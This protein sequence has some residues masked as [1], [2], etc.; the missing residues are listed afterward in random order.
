MAEIKLVKFNENAYLAVNADVRRNVEL[1]AHSSALEHFLRHGI[2]ENRAPVLR[3]EPIGLR[4]HVEFFFVSD[5]GFFAVGGWIADEG[6]GPLRCRLVGADFS[7]EISPTE[8]CRFARKDVEGIIGGGAY[9]YGVFILGSSFSK[10]LLKQSLQF[11]CETPAG[12]FE[13]RLTPQIVSN[14]RL[15]NFSLVRLQEHDSHEGREY[16]LY[17]FL[18]HAGENL[19]EM[20]RAQL[21][22]KTKDPY[23]ESFGKRSVS[24]SFIT[25]L[26]GSTEAIKLQPMLFRA[27]GVD[28]GEWIYVCNSPEDG[29]AALRLGR[30]MSELYDVAITVVVMADNVGFGAAN[31][32]GV[33]AAQSQNIYVV[34]PDVFPLRSGL[35]NLRRTLARPSLG[36]TLWGGLLFYDELNLM[37]SGMYMEHDVFVHRNTMARHDDSVNPVAKLVRVEHFDKCVPFDPALWTRPR[38]TPAIS[39]A[40]MAFDRKHFERI[41]G[42]SSR[43]IFGHYEDADLSLRWGKEIGPVVIDPDLQLMHLEGQGSRSRGDQYKAAQ[44]INRYLFSLKYND[45]FAKDPAMMTGGARA[46]NSNMTTIDAKPALDAA[47]KPELEPAEAAV[48]GMA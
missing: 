12:G 1:G 14:E 15:L 6:C 20:F 7:L 35:A 27:A 22:E 4:G 41:G 8:V 18:T 28:F 46:A 26:F 21:K 34:N 25:V 33:E 30:A 10:T 29:E 23:I 39:G 48:A 43:Y 13:T 37:H 16:N 44:I 36:E 9:D 38:A 2:D 42:F 3:R 19:V 31:N 5:G 11:V 47:S 32:I 45:E 40:V 24:R 17:R